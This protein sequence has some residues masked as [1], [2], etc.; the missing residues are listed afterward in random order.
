VKAAVRGVAFVA[1]VSVAAD[2]GG[3]L[4]KGLDKGRGRG[5]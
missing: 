5:T 4:S 3:K 2:M 1:F